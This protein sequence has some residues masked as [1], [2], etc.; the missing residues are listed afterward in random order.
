[1]KKISIIF[2]ALAATAVSA[3][4]CLEREFEEGTP[5]FSVSNTEFFLPS[6][7]YEG[8][9]LVCD[10]IWVTCNRSWTAS[11]PDT[12]D[13]ISLD[14]DGH[15]GLSGVNERTPLVIKC[16]D[17]LA[18][19]DRSALL[20]VSSS[21]GKQTI[22]ITQGAIRRRLVLVKGER[23]YSDLSYEGDTLRIGFNTN[24]PWTAQLKQGSTIDVLFDSSKGDSSAEI[25]AIVQENDDLTTSKQGTIVINAEG[26]RSIEIPVT[27][28][29]G[30]PIFRMECANEIKLDEGISNFEVPIHTNM[31]WKAE[32]IS[33]K[34][35]DSTK[36]LGT[37]GIK[38]MKLAKIT[39]PYC[40]NFGGDGEIVVR[41][42]ADK[43]EGEQI[44]TL[45]QDPC[46]R[47][48]VGNLGSEE[49]YTAGAKIGLSANNWPFAS[50]VYSYLT[51]SY[52]TAKDMN[53]VTEWE[54]LNGYKLTAFSPNGF[55]KNSTTGWMFGGVGSYL[56]LPAVEGFALK[57]FLLCYR[58]TGTFKGDVLNPNKEPVCERFFSA[59]QGVVIKVVTDGAK[60][61]EAI[62]IYAGDGT[63]FDIGEMTLHYE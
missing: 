36:V 43:V 57:D 17:N 51:T 11:V 9:G 60:P 6:D 49:M 32:L 1:M 30:E 20:S 2:A 5:V 58:G 47:F 44:L 16:T 7:M 28:L 25:E 37:S 41:F 59:G 8:Q 46:I 10:T 35:Y 24:C 34:G 13:W 50:P 54:L 55:W 52:T 23:G 33:V 31:S 27:Q 26:C 48:G 22:N 19:Q 15:Q 21:A 3:V 39:F 4:S 42:T 63:N 53:K 14:K 61:G 38:G 62:G 45:R 18:D 40:T 29:I 56:I 12:L